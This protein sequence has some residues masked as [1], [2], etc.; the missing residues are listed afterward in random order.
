METPYLTKD[1]S[2]IGSIWDDENISYKQQAIVLVVEVSHRFIIM[3]QTNLWNLSWTQVGH[4]V[5][6]RFQQYGHQNCNS[7]TV[8]LI[9]YIISFTYIAIYHIFLCS[10]LRM[11]WTNL[12]FKSDHCS[13]WRTYRQHVSVVSAHIQMLGLFRASQ[14]DCL[15]ITWRRFALF[16]GISWLTYRWSRPFIL[17]IHHMNV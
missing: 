16:V 4:T 13:I 9:Y 7:L 5:V 12:F 10:R 8:M 11:A 1:M 6:P 2:S 14:N 3:L 15:E 17:I